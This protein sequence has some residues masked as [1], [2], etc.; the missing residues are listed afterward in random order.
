MRHI[1]SVLA[2]PIVPITCALVSVL[3]A[4]TV[5]S[6]IHPT[7]D[8]LQHPQQAEAEGSFRRELGSRNVS[9]ISKR[10]LASLEQPVNTIIP[11]KEL[12]LQE[13]LN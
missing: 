3:S 5:N 9:T 13:G 8:W 4:S 7:V 2:S 12:D 11:E 1:Q 10:A 6:T